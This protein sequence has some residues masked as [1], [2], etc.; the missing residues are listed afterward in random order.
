[1]DLATAAATV[2]SAPASRRTI[3]ANWGRS[4]LSQ[5]T[6]EEYEQSGLISSSI[7]WRAAG[8]EV[9]PT[10]ATGEVVVFGE[11]LFRGFS[12]PGN[13]FFRQLLAH[14]KL[15]IHDLAPDSILNLSNFVT[16][17]EDYLQI[18]PD[19]DLWLELF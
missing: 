5:E 17:C 19:L 11:H 8:E 6:L 3:S 13:L 18:K 2:S 16:L 9:E 10:P 15:R 12:P 4:T 14:Y 7:K 1:M